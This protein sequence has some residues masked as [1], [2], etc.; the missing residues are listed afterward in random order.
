MP[1]YQSRNAARLNMRR[2]GLGSL[3][4]QSASGCPDCAGGEAPCVTPFSFRNGDRPAHRAPAA[5]Y[6]F[7]TLFRVFVTVKTA[8]SCADTLIMC[9]VDLV[10]VGDEVVS[11]VR[12][13]SPGLGRMEL[14]DLL[15]PG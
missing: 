6:V 11:G 4:V 8:I 1:P 7:V 13:V 3:E 10:Q 2:D 14:P 12:I 15:Q 9:E 5:G